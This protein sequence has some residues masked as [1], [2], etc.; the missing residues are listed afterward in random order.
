MAL[1]VQE[2]L[3][4]G[5]VCWLLGKR[6]GVTYFFLFLSQK[7]SKS[8]AEISGVQ[9][10]RFLECTGLA[11]LTG[12]RGLSCRP[13][14][15]GRGLRLSGCSKLVLG[16]VPHPSLRV[17][18]ADSSGFCWSSGFFFFFSLYL[19]GHFSG[20]WNIVLGVCKADVLTWKSGRASCKLVRVLHLVSIG[21]GISIFMIFQLI[22]VNVR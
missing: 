5:G 15:G 7:S 19:R 17:K 2:K 8:A 4:V 6:F 22:I 16:V 1:R 21:P 13:Y 14:T 3:K 12:K 20:S 18:E 11:F 10:P 9:L